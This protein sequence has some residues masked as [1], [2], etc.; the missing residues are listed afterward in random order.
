MSFQ[1]K[2]RFLIPALGALLLTAGAIQAAWAAPG[3]ID[4]GFNGGVPAIIDSSG[5]DVQAIEAAVNPVNSDIIWA[6]NNYDD[7]SHATTGQ[8]AVYKPDGSLDT[9]VGRGGIIPLTP[10]DTGLLGDDLTFTAVAVDGQGRILAT[11][12]VSSSSSAAMILVRFKPDGTLDTSFG[13]SGNGVASSTLNSLALGTDISLTADGHI[14]VTGDAPDASVLEQQLTIWRFNGDGTA[15]SSFGDGGH[16]QI[17]SIASDHAHYCLD[18]LQPDDSLIAGCLATGTS[19]TPGPWKITRLNTDGSVDTSFGA[20]G[21]VT[22]NTNMAL[23]GIAPVPNGGF[24]ISEQDTSAS[25]NPVDLQRYLADG[26]VDS[27]FNG[28]SPVSVGTSSFELL[29]LTVQPDGKIVASMNDN[30]GTGAPDLLKIMRVLVDGTPDPDFGNTG[31]AGLSVL[32][33]RGIGGVDYKPEPTGVLLQGDGKI[34]VTGE[35]NYPTNHSAAFVTR[36]DNGAL[37]F[38]PDTVSFMDQTDV[39][40]GVTI[41]SNAVT[42]SGLTDGVS[43]PVSVSGGEYKIN[44]SAWTSQPGMAQNGDQIAVRHTSS[45]ENS[46]S[47]TTTLAIGG[48]VIPNNNSTMLGTPVSADFTSTTKA[49]S[50]GG[51]GSGGGSTGGGGSSGSSGG[52][53]TFGNLGL[54]LLMGCTL[55]A[56]LKRQWAKS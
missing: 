35:A 17:A 14:L 24:V 53:G 37:T 47:T 28:G 22:G 1:Q 30:V 38:T 13:P 23:A 54:L 8:I 26:S 29:P 41:T 19:S 10:T 40:T 27:T 3:D 51:G 7:T 12:Y 52:G 49:A 46:T 45:S 20:S 33:F 31:D 11:G 16:V 55:L 2:Y 36:I 56:G 18:A 5:N 42:V 4:A 39:D 50:T 15:D 32:D 21:Y 44:D 6:G 25:P 48:E 34:V 9:S 43:V